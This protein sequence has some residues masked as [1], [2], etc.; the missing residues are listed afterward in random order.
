MFFLGQLEDVTE[1]LRW[2]LQ[3]NSKTSHEDRSDL[4]EAFPESS[5]LIDTLLREIT[6]NKAIA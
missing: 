3:Q 2:T 1:A 6:N 4:P 5:G